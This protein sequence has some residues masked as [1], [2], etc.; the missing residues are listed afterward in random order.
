MTVPINVHLCSHILSPYVPHLFTH[1]GALFP[2]PF[3]FQ[4]INVHLTPCKILFLSHFSN[5][6]PFKRCFLKHTKQQQ[7]AYRP[8]VV[9]C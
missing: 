7:G 9:G 2:Y 8:P 1:H 6:K 4:P 5:P 3:T